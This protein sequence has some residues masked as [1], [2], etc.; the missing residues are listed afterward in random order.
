MKIEK[1]RF[2]TEDEL[3]LF[4]LLHLPEQKTKK[5]VIF[6]HGMHSNCL[7]ERDDRI[8]VLE[9][10]LARLMKIDDNDDNDD[11]IELSNNLL[12]TTV[13]VLELLNDKDMDDLSDFVHPT[14]GVRFS[15]YGYIDVD[16]HLVFTAGQVDDLDDDTE[17]YTWGSY[18]GSGE[19]IDL[20]FDDYY[21]DFIFDVDFSD[22][23]LIGNNAIIG[24]GNSLINIEEVYPDGHFVELHFTGFDPQYEG[25]DWRSLRLVFETVNG[26]WYL[27]GIIHDEWT[28]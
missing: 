3:K 4:G 10:E 1:I 16:N 12:L 18:D 11:D 17:V 21:Y 2:M 27:V 28:I 5:V 14:K 26:D 15:P 9:Q 13:N 25:I 7:K 22:P 19:D 20:D 6:I 24:I 8:A 23:E